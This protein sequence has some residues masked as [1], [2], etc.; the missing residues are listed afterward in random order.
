MASINTLPNCH[1]NA[2]LNLLL[3]KDIGGWVWCR[4]R[5]GLGRGTTAKEPPRKE[6]E[7]AAHGS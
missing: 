1:F 7:Y 3:T 6:S 5:R 4:R 2:A